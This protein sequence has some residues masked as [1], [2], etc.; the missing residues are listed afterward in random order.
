MLIKIE[1]IIIDIQFGLITPR[2][3]SEYLA[4]TFILDVYISHSS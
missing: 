3:M 1:G 4:I 2:L